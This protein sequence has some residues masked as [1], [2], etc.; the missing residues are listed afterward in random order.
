MTLWHC[1]KLGPRGLYPTSIG[2]RMW[3]ALG[4][5]VTLL[6]LSKPRN[7]ESRGVLGG[8]VVLVSQEQSGQPE[9]QRSGMK[10]GVWAEPPRPTYGSPHLKNKARGRP[11]AEWLSLCAQLGWSKVSP[12]QI[13][14]H[15]AMLRQRPT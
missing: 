10:D 9:D 3:A 4:R 11:E 2:H 15:Q 7:G 5:G 13:L 12:V 1:S 8:L 14:G 6:V